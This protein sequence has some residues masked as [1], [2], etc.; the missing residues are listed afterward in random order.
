ML[1][2]PAPITRLTKCSFGDLVATKKSGTHGTSQ[3][4]AGNIQKQGFNSGPG[5]AGRGIYF[6]AESPLA[7]YLAECW[8]AQQK[9]WARTF[10]YEKDPNCAVIH[11]DISCEELEYINLEDTSLKARI[12]DLALQHGSD[13]DDDKTLSSLNALIIGELEKELG[14]TMKLL[15]IRVAP[16]DK[17]FAPKYSLKTFGA[18]VCYVVRDKRCITISKVS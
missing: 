14:V 1:V 4:R 2:S 18:P 7:V 5:R 17:R 8:Y 9:A 3:Q 11:V 12:M 10:N 6:W 13:L 16:P 15:E